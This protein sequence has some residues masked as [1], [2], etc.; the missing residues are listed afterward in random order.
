MGI[1]PTVVVTPSILASMAGSPATYTSLSTVAPPAVLSAAAAAAAANA[2]GTASVKGETP[3][4]FLLSKIVEI[5]QFLEL[6]I[7]Y[8]NGN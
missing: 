7:S 1:E 3:R 8:K 2:A 5:G 4:I 6:S